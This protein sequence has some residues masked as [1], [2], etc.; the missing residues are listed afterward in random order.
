MWILFSLAAAV[1]AAIVVVL[2]KAGIKQLDATLVFG[3]ESICIVIVTWSIIIVKR[4]QHQVSTIDRQVWIFIIAAGV[5]TAL[6]SIFSFHSLKIGH[7]SR[8][9][10]FEKVSLVI[11]AILAIIFLKDKFNW[12]LCLGVLMMIAGAVLIGFSDTK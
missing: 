11:S 4:L 8:T 9:A 12:Q 10:S 2:S 1:F 7:A 6:S 3:L 5:L